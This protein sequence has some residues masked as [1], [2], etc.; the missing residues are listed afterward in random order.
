MGFG[1]LIVDREDIMITF[2]VDKFNP[3]GKRI[4]GVFN[5]LLLLGTGNRHVLLFYSTDDERIRTNDVDYEGADGL[6]LYPSGTV[7]GISRIDI[8]LPCHSGR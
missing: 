1:K 3:L 4:M 5:T 2:L 8:H 6:V 7:N